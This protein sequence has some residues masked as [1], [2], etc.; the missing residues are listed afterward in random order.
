MDRYRRGALLCSDDSTSLYEIEGSPPH[1]VL[2]VSKTND[3]ERASL[4]LKSAIRQV[5][6]RSSLPG[7]IKA[8]FV[9]KVGG[10]RLSIERLIKKSEQESYRELLREEDGTEEPEDLRLGQLIYQHLDSIYGKEVFLTKTSPLGRSVTVKVYTCDFHNLNELVQEA[11][12]LAKAQSQESNTIIDIACRLGKT[13]PF[14]L[15][16][17]VDKLKLNLERDLHQRC[18]AYQLYTETELLLILSDLSAALLFAKFQVRPKQGIVHRDI[19]PSHIYLHKGHYKLAWCRSACRVDDSGPSCD[20][21]MPYM[22]PE[23]RKLMIGEDIGIDLFQS[24]IFPF[25]VAMLHLT[26]LELP[27]AI[28]AEW[29]DSVKLNEA[30]SSELQGLCYSAT[31]LDFLRKMLKMKPNE[32]PRIEEIR[33]F[34]ISQLSKSPL[35][36]SESPTFVPTSLIAQ[37]KTYLSR[38]QFQEAEV[39]LLQHLLTKETSEPLRPA[40]RHAFALLYLKQGKYSQSR[41]MLED[42]ELLDRNR[43]CEE[44]LERNLTLAEAYMKEGMLKQAENALKQGL[45][46]QIDLYQETNSGIIQTYALLGELYRLKR[47]YNEAKTMLLCSLELSNRFFPQPTDSTALIWASLGCL[48]EDLGD[49]SEAERLFRQS[50]SIAISGNSQSCLAA[51][52]CHLSRCYL[53]QNRSSE[54]EILLNKAIQTASTALGPSHPD[55]THYTYHLALLYTKE[56]R[57]SAAETLYL[58]CIEAQSTA[59]GEDNSTTAAY[60]TALALNYLA[61]AEKDHAKAILT[62]VIHT[63]K[64]AFGRA[65]HTV[66]VANYHLARILTEEGNWEEAK[67]LLLELWIIRVAKYGEIS[68]ETAEICIQMENLY[69]EMGDVVAAAEFSRRNHTILIKLHLSSSPEQAKSE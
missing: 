10:R 39:F 61:K 59:F 2:K 63:Q 62:R 27:R 37:T 14:E 16:L 48:Y 42:T 69:R 40:E 30:V 12:I 43:P 9:R 22:S 17:V 31:Y 44:S 57:L 29:R 19:K 47:T 66:S 36:L 25:G 65:N 41:K 38:C 21:S 53:A 7:L 6:G 56:K 51:A 35:F 8:V 5:R 28:S 45:K 26:K 20:G 64:R 18:R 15:E 1:T 3:V 4:V 60:S 13:S 23:M 54:A 34:A 11:M 55:V 68:E 33:L 67:S 50:H 46:L 52:F 32:R 49:Y 58:Q 24:D